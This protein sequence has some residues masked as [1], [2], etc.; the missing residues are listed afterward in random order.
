MNVR[1]VTASAAL[2]M[3][4]G[5]ASAADLV[6]ETPPAPVEPRPPG[7]LRNR[8]WISGGKE[9]DPEFERLLAE[10]EAIERSTRQH[11]ETPKFHGDGD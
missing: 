10:E 11:H 9:A 2:L 8:K 6:A 3:L 4:A 1:I 5:S 7:W